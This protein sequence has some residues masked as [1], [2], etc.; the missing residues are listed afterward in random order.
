LAATLEA[1]A[2]ARK[3]VEEAQS[4]V[5]QL[6]KLREETT[7]AS[8]LADFVRDRGESADYR[9]LLTEVSMVNRDLKDLAELTN[10]YNAASITQPGG[11]PNRIVLYIDDLDRCPPERVVDVLEAVHLLLSFELF[12]VVVAVDTRWLTSALHQGLSALSD[13]QNP[14][15]KEATAVDY[16]EKIFQIPFWVDPLDESAR[17]RLLHGLVLRSVRKPKMVKG[18][19]S[20]GALNVGAKEEEAVREVLSRY[21]SWLDP[22][23]RQLSISVDELSF[24]E[25]LA[26]LIGNTP[27]RVKRFVNI[28]HLL[29]SMSPPLS[30]DDKVL[31]ERMGTCLMAAIHEGLPLLAQH[32]GSRATVPATDPATTLRQALTGLS[33][34]VDLEGQ[35]FEIWLKKHNA[36]LPAGSPHLETIALAR[37]T[38][39]WNMTRRLGFNAGSDQK[40]TGPPENKGRAT[41]T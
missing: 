26:P 8:S 12:V 19:E 22:K 3:D 18:S 28:C 31:S 15:D 32:L 25:S 16:L 17:Q 34:P 5:E 11:P 13:A 24:L 27:R 40:P 35:R 20:G 38:S 7:A 9:R 39:R 30:D 4:T 2:Q 6:T 33:G 37:L 1:L 23:A 21:G 14:L 29:L 36:Q 41:R 10:E